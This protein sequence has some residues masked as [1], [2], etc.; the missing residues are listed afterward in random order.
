MVFQ[1]STTLKDAIKTD[2]SHDLD[3]LCIQFHFAVAFLLLWM[4][5][6][7]HLCLNKKSLE[8]RRNIL[9]GLSTEKISFKE[10]FNTP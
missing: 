4:I 9:S 5:C 8:N 7:L 10:N 6:V 1:V 3:I 2:N